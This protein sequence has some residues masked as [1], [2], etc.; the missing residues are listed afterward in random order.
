[1]EEPVHVLDFRQS[2]IAKTRLKRPPAAGIEPRSPRTK[3][4]RS[5]R[6]TTE[7]AGP[8]RVSVN[9]MKIFF[10]MTDGIY[11]RHTL[12]KRSLI[13]ACRMYYMFT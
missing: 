1:M 10:C 8:G 5:E 7:L 11:S 12:I 3:I 9:R 4:L 13:K 6:S 2:F